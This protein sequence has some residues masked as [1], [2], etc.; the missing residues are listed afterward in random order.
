MTDGMSVISEA[1]TVFTGKITHAERNL[2]K[3]GEKKGEDLE[4]L[5]MQV[6]ESKLEMDEIKKKYKA[7]LAR[8][9][10]LEK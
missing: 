9:D 6:D 4:K 10:T 3:L 5:K 2:K 7:S 1:P 8:R